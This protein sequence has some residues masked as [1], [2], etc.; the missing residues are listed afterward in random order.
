M[1][2]AT[3]QRSINYLKTLIEAELSKES[4]TNELKDHVD[5]SQE[6]SGHAQEKSRSEFDDSDSEGINDD[7]SGNP[8]SE[9]AGVELES[10]LKAK[11]SFK[12]ILVSIKCFKL[13]EY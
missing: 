13:R 8:L 10:Y 7:V 12:G 2:H 4:G 9:K 6:E 1:D 5:L 11:L 3:R